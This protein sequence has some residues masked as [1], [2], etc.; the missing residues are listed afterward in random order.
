MKESWKIVKKHFI[1][2]FEEIFADPTFIE[3]VCVWP[4]IIFTVAFSSAAIAVPI[5]IH[6]NNDVSG[7]V[8]LSYIVTIPI[9]VVLINASANWFVKVYKG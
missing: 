3:K 6:A 8:F 7:L 2:S 1:E 9:E 4:M 5:I